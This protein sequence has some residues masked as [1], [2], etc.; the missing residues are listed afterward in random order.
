MEDYS[1]LLDK[2]TAKVEGNVSYADYVIDTAE[3][4]Y[5]CDAP[6]WVSPDELYGYEG[7]IYT[8]WLCED[9]LGISESLDL[10]GVSVRGHFCDNGEVFL[11]SCEGVSQEAATRF[12]EAVRPRVTR[13]YPD[14]IVRS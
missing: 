11:D 2:F 12:L 3:G 13:H 8:F 10:V 7:E 6:G 5:F 14:T 9:D 1:E 4:E